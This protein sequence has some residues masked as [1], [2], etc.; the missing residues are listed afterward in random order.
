MKLTYFLAA[1]LTAVFIILFFFS[2]KPRKFY[3][4]FLLFFFPLIDLPISSN[5]WGNFRVF[6]GISYICFFAL[7]KEFFIFRKNNKNKIYL[8][9]SFICVLLI[10]S[11]NSNFL[12]SSLLSILS[13]FPVFIYATLLI[14]ECSL[15]RNFQNR[16]IRL[17]K[18]SAI[19]S[20]IFFILQ[21]KFG[22]Q[23]T[24]YAT[25][26]LN[27]NIND[28]N[29]LRYMSFFPEPQSFGQFL[30][31]VSFMFL[32]NNK[33]IKRPQLINYI[34]L[35]LVFVGMIAAGSRSAF[36]GF[37]PGALLLFFVLDKRYKL[38][39]LCVFISFLALVINYS[40]SLVILNRSKNF[41]NDLSFR[42][43]LWNEAKDI[44]LNYPIFGIGIGNYKNYAI[45]TNSDNFLLT[46]E[47]QPIFF[48]QPESGYWKI[49]TETGTTGFIFIFSFIFLPIINSLKKIINGKIDFKIFFY[50]SSVLCWLI[51]FVSLY[52]VFDKRILIVVVT[53]ICL[54]QACNKKDFSY[55]N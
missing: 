42:A 4:Q 33:N 37:I 11:L 41:N 25:I 48:N 20:I 10:G 7:F 38:A 23:F 40:N 6:D 50:I 45:L 52:S 34:L 13:I 18:F 31:I 53:F 54:I 47:K 27:E 8:F 17:L 2:K 35:G 55:E 21:L 44:Y 28:S 43:S 5:D 24:F 22:I 36:L 26:D 9:S 14:K 51:T 49:L 30:S 19:V 16:I 1:G 29:G 39:L 3:L 12:T 15:D 46:P 32:I